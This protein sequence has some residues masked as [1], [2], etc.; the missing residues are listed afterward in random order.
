MNHSF[1]APICEWLHPTFSRANDAGSQVIISQMFTTE[2]DPNLAHIEQVDCLRKSYTAPSARPHCIVSLI[3]RHLVITIPS[4]HHPICQFWL[5]LRFANT[6][7]IPPTLLS[8]GSS[9]LGAKLGSFAESRDLPPVLFCA[10][11]AY[12]LGWIIIPPN[13]GARQSRIF[14]LASLLRHKRKF[15]H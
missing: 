4:E 2:L 13:L 10:D 6:W 8:D 1:L 12:L 14:Y 11:F 5:F 3:Q 7:P 9:I 15:R